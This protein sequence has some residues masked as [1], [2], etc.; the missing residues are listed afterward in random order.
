MYGCMDVWMYTYMHVLHACMYMHVHVRVRVHMPVHV[1]VHVHGHVYVHVLGMLLYMYMY[2]HGYVCKASSIPILAQAVRLSRAAMA[3][4]PYS[5]WTKWRTDTEHSMRSAASGDPRGSRSTATSSTCARIRSASDS[6]A[7]ADS[8]PKQRRTATEHSSAT[9]RELDP[10]IQL[11]KAQTPTDVS[12]K[13]HHDRT[14]DVGIGI[15]ILMPSDLSLER[16][17]EMIEGEEMIEYYGEYIGHGQSKTAFELNCPG[18]PFHGQVLKV[19]KAHDT[20]PS[21]FREAALASLTTNV[22][23]NCEGK[24]VASGKR[25]HCWITDRAIPLDD[26]CRNCHMTN[27]N[28]NLSRCGLAAFCC[29]LKAAQNGLCLDDC[30]F[31]NFG[32]RL[33]ESATEHLVVI[34][35]AGSRGIDTREERLKKSVINKT[36]MHRFWKACAEESATPVAIKQMWQ[37]AGTTIDDCLKAATDDWEQWPFLTERAESTCGIWQGMIADRSF[38]RSQAHAT[39]AYKIMEIVGRFTAEDQW[40]AACA[41]ACYRAAD[42]MRSKLRVEEW[43]LDQLFERLTHHR[44]DEELHQVMVFWGRLNEHRNRECSDEQSVT[45]ENMIESFKHNQLWYEL[46]WNQ[47]GRGWRSTANA[48]LH[49]R[50][51]WKHAATAIMEHGLPKLEQPAQPADATEHIN[52]LGQFAHDMAQWLLKFALRTHA[53]MDTEEYQKSYQTSI[54]AMKKRSTRKM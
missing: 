22:L 42:D 4:N 17:Q 7:G 18:E 6:D 24:D 20:E 14:P 16:G 11:Q 53:Y 51:G 31:F 49:K 12:L 45:P 46:T 52:T 8:V 34:I 26:F 50:A 19:A 33:T 21:V 29:I 3:G 35:D 27:N 13:K 41:V 30:R 37:Q 39:S 36:L 47:R 9:H 38:R 5:L 44:S 10:E 40:N 15:R 48:L 43:I 54:E 23:Y 1:R 28:A 2:V 32:V 25:F